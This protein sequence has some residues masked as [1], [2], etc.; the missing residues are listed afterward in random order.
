MRVLYV[1]VCFVLVAAVCHSQR[2]FIRYE[3]I[4]SIHIGVVVGVFGTSHHGTID[5]LWR[6]IGSGEFVLETQGRDVSKHA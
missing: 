6:W 1:Y 3:I 2:H 4:A 5:D